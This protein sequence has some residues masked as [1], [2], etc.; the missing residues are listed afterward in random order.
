MNQLL[1]E[2]DSYS[3]SAC[4]QNSSDFESYSFENWVN[5]DCK[6]F[7]AIEDP[8]LLD[9]ESFLISNS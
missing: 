4:N 6:S 8:C 3:P 1:T 5:P 7:F 9:V 2:Y